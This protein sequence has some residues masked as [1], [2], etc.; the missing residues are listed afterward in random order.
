M[1]LKIFVHYDDTGEI[2]AM[3]HEDEL[4]Y[5]QRLSSGE[6]ILEIEQQVDFNR[7][8]VNLNTMRLVEKPIT[9]PTN[10]GATT[11]Q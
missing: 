5:N 3:T 7:Y 11:P 8:K 4:F 10:T 9:L 2:Y 6:K 1:S